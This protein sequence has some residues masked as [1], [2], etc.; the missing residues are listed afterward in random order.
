MRNILLASSLLWA[1]YCSP[2]MAA[3][4]VFQ[5]NG[6]AQEVRTASAVYAYQPPSEAASSASAVAEMETAEPALG[7]R[8][9]AFSAQAGRIWPGAA[10]IPAS[11]STS[12]RLVQ[13]P[14]KAMA[15]MS[16]SDDLLFYFL[17]DFRAKPPQKPA[18]WAMLLIAFSL[19]LYQVRRRPM[20][21]SIGFGSVPRLAGQHA[22]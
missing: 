20:R 17:R 16:A 9:D 18:L 6:P 10:I 4:P 15:G 8:P 19:L 11:F 1:A 22:I 14:K 5:L 3:A 12:P 13:V 2:V 21:T 7:E